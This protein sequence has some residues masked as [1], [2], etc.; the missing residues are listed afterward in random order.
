MGFT[1][2]KGSEE[3]I[4]PNCP[5]VTAE[6]LVGI[7]VEVSAHMTTVRTILS[8]DLSVAAVSSK[9]NKDL[10]IVE[11]DILSAEKGVTRLIHID[12]NNRLKPGDLIVTSGTSG[13]FPKDYSVG[14][15]QSVSRDSNGLSDCAVIEPCSDISR[16]TSV[17]VITDFTGKREE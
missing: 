9:N 16:L 7:T 14:K 11:G 3:G 2:D 17:Y 6:G 12:K 5:V 1:I 15:V 8:P 10:G 13:L 4:T